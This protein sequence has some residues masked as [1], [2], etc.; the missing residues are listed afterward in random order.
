[1]IALL[2]PT[3][4]RLEQFRR[5]AEFMKRQ[6]YDGKVVWVIVDDCVPKT[7]DNVTEYFRDN[8]IIHKVYPRPAWTYNQNTQ[9]RNME[10]GLNAVMNYKPEAIFVIEDDDYY[11][12]IYLERMMA[13]FGDYWAIGETRTIYYNVAYRRYLVNGNDAHA[14]L[15]QTAIRPEAVE[16]MMR[17]NGSLF[18]D[19]EFWS[20]VPNKKLFHEGNLSI[21][22]KGMPGR[23]GIGYGHREA[24]RMND[25]CNMNYL[26]SIIGEDYKFYE[27]CFQQYKKSKDILTKW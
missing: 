25:D 21:G 13:N 16:Y 7:T 8:W 26:K 6:T 10:A 12:S 2:T 27:G 4:N 15:F 5:C 23:R 19:A 1:M 17:S 18:I 24:M 22:I 20:K 9:G 11:K 3:G 14:S